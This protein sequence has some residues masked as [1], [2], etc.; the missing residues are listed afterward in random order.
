MRILHTSDWHLGRRIHGFDVGDAHARFLDWLVPLVAERG[1]DAVLVSGDVYDRAIPHPDALDLWDR[2]TAELLATGTRLIATSGNHDSFIRL[3]VGRRQL[4]A[5]GLHLRTR[6]SD[7]DRPVRLGYDGRM[8]SP[9]DPA[10]GVSVHGIP[11]L[12]PALVWERMGAPARTHTAVLGAAM[13]RIRAVHAEREAA[14][15][16]ADRRV[17][18]AHAFVTGSV[19]SES[20]RDISVGGVGAAPLAG[21]ADC[22]Y[23]ALGHVHRPQDLAPGVRY[24]GS[25]LPFSFGES[26][27]TKRVL[28]VEFSGPD[29]EPAVMEHPIPEFVRLRT[30]TGSLEA[31]LGEAAGHQ[32]A[33]VSAE[34]TD[35]RRVPGALERLRRAFPGFVR[36]TWTGL[37]EPAA[38]RPALTAAAAARRTDRQVFE[39][40]HRA[41]RGT[42]APAHAVERFES[43]LV[44]VLSQSETAAGARGRG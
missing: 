43:A 19:S 21:F 18:L 8:L 3:G 36:M 16:P 27:Q 38:P 20:E 35:A 31:V 41:Q 13:D 2:A 44:T 6:L 1:I 37:S 17:V 7:I 39:E 34:L 26:G 33:L 14:G 22:D 23:A 24:S 25:P 15:L 12:E 28:E 32:D 11:Y 40:F 5:A 10:P 29:R 4:E 42:A 30:L 9:D